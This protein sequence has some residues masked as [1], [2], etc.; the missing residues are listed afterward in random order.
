VE[1]KVDI[2]ILRFL[3]QID[4]GVRFSYGLQ[5]VQGTLFEVLIGTINF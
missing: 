1:A 4:I 5:P 3:P 2:N